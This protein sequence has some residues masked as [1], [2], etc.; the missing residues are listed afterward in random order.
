MKTTF[1]L[2]I[3]CFLGF[4]AVAQVKVKW[5][6]QAGFSVC[7]MA[8]S[9]GDFDDIRTEQHNVPGFHTGLVTDISLTRILLLRTG[10][11]VERR[12]FSYEINQS[13]IHYEAIYRPM[14][15]QIPAIIALTN[16]RLY[17]GAGPY[18]A[19]GLGGTYHSEWAGP[20]H[21]PLPEPQDRKIKWGD[22]A[23]AN[24][25]QRLDAGLQL[26][27]GLTVRRFRLSGAYVFGLANLQPHPDAAQVVKRNRILAL[28][29]SAFL[30]RP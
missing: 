25:F 28:S 1:L 16:G 11:Q 14:Y 9:G 20:S 23:E 19:Y 30:S 7:R 12:G 15:V 26:E 17:A 22:N 27:A 3:F 2:C 21:L 24:D 10:L 8:S 6:L 13:G 29:L 5:G 4:P 18:A